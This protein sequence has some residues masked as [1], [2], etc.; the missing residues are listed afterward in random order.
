MKSVDKWAEAISSAIKASEGFREAETKRQSQ[1]I[2]EANLILE[3]AMASLK[4]RYEIPIFSR[5][6][7]MSNHLPSNVVLSQFQT[8]TERS[9]L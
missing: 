9:S 4:R 5:I 7:I 6:N 3:E 1:L 2:D 8:L